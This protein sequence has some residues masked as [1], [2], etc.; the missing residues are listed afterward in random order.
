MNDTYDL[1]PEKPR[2]QPAQENL[3]YWDGLR[4]HR[5]LVQRCLSCNKLRHYPRPMCDSC[6]SMEY[7]W[8][9]IDGRGT[10]HSWT[11]SHHPFHPGFKRELPY[12]TVTADLEAGLRLQAPLVGGDSSSLRLGLPVVVEYTDVDEALS[13]PCLRLVT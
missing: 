2:P 10:V 8:Q 1:L 6:Y 11:V 12:V 13:L 7:D 3:A 5:L 4:E 9:E